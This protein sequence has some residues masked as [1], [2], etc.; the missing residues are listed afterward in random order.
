MISKCCYSFNFF[1]CSF[2]YSKNC[3]LTL[4][5]FLLC[6]FSHSYFYS[7]IFNCSILLKQASNTVSDGLAFLTFLNNSDKKVSIHQFPYNINSLLC[8][9]ANSSIF[10]N[11]GGY[12]VSDIHTFSTYFKKPSNSGPSKQPLIHRNFSITL[13][14]GVNAKHLTMAMS[15]LVWS[16]NAGLRNPLLA[17]FSHKALAIWKNVGTTVVLGNTILIELYNDNSKSVPIYSGFKS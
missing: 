3:N 1:F 6:K 11:D 4:S 10:H 7:R 2:L 5:K 15:F 8:N 9:S 12:G 17:A 14:N 16:T 13:S